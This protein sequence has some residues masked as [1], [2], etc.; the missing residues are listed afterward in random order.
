MLEAEGRTIG[1]VTGVQG[2]RWYE[3][4]VEGEDAHAGTTPMG[5]RRDALLAAARMI[6]AV[7]AAALRHGPSAVATVGLI[8]A[9]PNSRNVVP[10]RVFFTIDLRHPEEGVLEA[11][12]G[13]V[14]AELGAVAEA[15]GVALGFERVW[16]APPVS[17]AEECIAAV[18]EAA[19]GLGLAW[20]E[21]VSGAGHDAA[22]VAAVAPTAMIFI[23]CARGLSHNEAEW[24]EPEHVT[25]GG[26]V[27]LRAVL[28]TDARLA[29]QAGGQ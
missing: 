26:D 21:I 29:E 12:E 7:H 11:M 15:V 28:A 2:M 14:R 20:R 4:T 8:E 9:S 3:V 1:V 6:E 16:H 23:P 22:Y 17:F 24:A 27:L 19:E 10:G 13:G 25:A 5:L 18:R